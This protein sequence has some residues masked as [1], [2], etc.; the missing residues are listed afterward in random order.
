MEEI[1]EETSELTP[2][3]YEFLTSPLTRMEAV[4]LLQPLRGALV[5]AAQGAMHSLAAL[6]HEL[7]EGEVK[8]RVVNSFDRLDDF[9]AQIDVFDTRM[10]NVMD[11]RR[12]TSSRSEDASDE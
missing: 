7:P 9:F 8:T 4:Q 1:T 10:T 6:I 3:I 5:P 12:P 2:E 11:G